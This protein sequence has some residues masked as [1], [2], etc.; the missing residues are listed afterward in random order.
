ML[1]SIPYN[2]AISGYRNKTL[3]GVEFPEYDFSEYRTGST[4]HRGVKAEEIIRGF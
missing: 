1:L 3:Q 2:D 4:H